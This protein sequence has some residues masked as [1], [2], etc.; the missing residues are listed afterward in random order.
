MT[1][2]KMYMYYKIQKSWDN[3]W[4]F[5]FFF[6]PLHQVKQINKNLNYGTY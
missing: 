5:Q 3:I 4:L 6:V 1:Q 2:E